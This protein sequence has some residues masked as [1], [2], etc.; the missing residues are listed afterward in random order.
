[1]F[2]CFKTSLEMYSIR[3]GVFESVGAFEVTEVLFK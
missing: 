1:M 3:L 2:E